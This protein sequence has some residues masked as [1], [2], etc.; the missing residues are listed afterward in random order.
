MHKL[1]IAFLCL[2]TLLQYIYTMPLQIT[3]LNSGSNGNCYYIGND[4]EA[5]LVDAGISCRETERRMRRLNLSMDKLKAIFISHEHI[6]HIRGMQVLQSKHKLPVYITAAT[7]QNSRMQL[8][9]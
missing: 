7:L 9:A 1:C 8:D 6:D 2:K 3:S 4:Q 5:V